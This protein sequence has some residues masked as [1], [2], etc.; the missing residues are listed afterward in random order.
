MLFIDLM[1]KFDVAFTPKP[2]GGATGSPV[3]DVESRLANAKSGKL[4]QKFYF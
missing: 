4:F 1:A 3:E 2:P